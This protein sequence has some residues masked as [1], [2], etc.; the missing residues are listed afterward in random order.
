MSRMEQIYWRM[1]YAL[2]CWMASRF[3]KKHDR[4][5]FGASYEEAKAAIADRSGWDRERFLAYQLE[6]LQTLVAHCHAKVPYYQDLFRSIGLEPGDIRSFADFQAIPVLDKQTFREQGDRFIAEGLDRRRLTAIHTSGTTGT[7]LT[8]YRDVKEFSLAFAYNAVRLW[9]AVGVERRRDR[10]ITLGG[11]RVVAPGATS[12]PFWVLNQRWKQL[13]M[14]SYHLS[15]RNLPHYVEAIARFEPGYIE[16]YPSSVFAIAQ[17]MLDNGLDPLPVKAVFTTAENLLDHQRAAIAAAFCCQC[18]S[19]YGCGEQVVYGAECSSRTMH[20]SPDHSFVEVVDDAGQPVPPGRSGNLVGTGLDKFVQPLL[21]YRLG[22]VGVL[23]MPDRRC[24][25]GLSL[26]I[27]E[28]I[29]GRA[30]DV[31]VTADGRLV[32]R[33]DPVFKS[34]TGILEAQIVQESLT[35]FCIR[36]VP[37]EKGTPDAYQS[38]I[39]NL[40]SRLGPTARIRTETTSSIERTQA[41]K[42]RAVVCRLTAEQRAAALRQGQSSHETLGG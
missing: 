19:Q 12:P 24:D 29:E 13:I 27:L 1:P 16:G 14:S 38:T 40:Q 18:Y 17:Y 2:R 41:G 3:A 4:L 30:D 8:I 28:Q 10:S 7:P 15:P 34:L 33:L 11:S 36:I 35:E 26:P 20:L 42:F 9:T 31:L 32:G 25:C 21:R 39:D 5:R 23:A 6:R 22:D 37:A